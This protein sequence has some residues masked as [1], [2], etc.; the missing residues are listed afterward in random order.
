MLE[1]VT[2]TRSAHE[3][4]AVFSEGVGGGCCFLVSLGMAMLMV[5]GGKF[6]WESLVCVW[7]KERWGVWLVSICGIF[8][9]PGVVVF[10]S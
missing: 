7:T 2:L 3:E 10:G 8:S 5:D 6:S 1:S 4:D 9:V